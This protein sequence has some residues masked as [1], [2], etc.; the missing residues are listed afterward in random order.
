MTQTKNC[1]IVKCIVCKK[2]YVKRLPGHRARGLKNTF[3]LRGNNTLTCSKHCSKMHTIA[4]HLK[5]YKS[6]RNKKI[7][8][9]DGRQC[10]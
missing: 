8:V 10:K 2:K 5:N 6:K 3:I 9:K 4:V 7:K 1:E